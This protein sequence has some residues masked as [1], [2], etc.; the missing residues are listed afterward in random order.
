MGQ[1]PGDGWI[2]L[3]RQTQLLES[4]TPP[5]ARRVAHLAVGEEA[6][7]QDAPGRL[8]VEIGRDGAADETAAAS[9][10]GDRM[11]IRA[12]G[13]QHRLLGGPAGVPQRD[14]LP[15]VH[16]GALGSEV[17]F[18]TWWASARSMLSPPTRM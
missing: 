2:G 15:G 13:G 17:G 6:V 14:R 3:E 16:C 1:M 10:D 7:E 11:N 5:A 8:P 18:A 12:A 9:L 4:R